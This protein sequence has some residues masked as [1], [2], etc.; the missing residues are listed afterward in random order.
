MEGRKNVLV[1]SSRWESEK[2]LQQAAL[3]GILDWAATRFPERRIDEDEPPD[4][5]E[6]RGYS[7]QAD[8]LFAEATKCLGFAC[9]L[10]SDACDTCRFGGGKPEPE[11]AMTKEEFVAQRFVDKF[12]RQS[13]PEFN[14]LVELSVIQTRH[15]AW[16]DLFA[17]TSNSR[18]GRAAS[19]LREYKRMG[20]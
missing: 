7:A 16:Y 12:E 19:E 15:E 20:L 6:R 8:S 18:G 10:T 11:S 3:R 2:R 17:R 1:P 9:P 4:G 5:V 13:F 14:L